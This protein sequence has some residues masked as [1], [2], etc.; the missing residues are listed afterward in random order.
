VNWLLVIGYL[1]LARDR[2]LPACKQGANNKQPRANQSQRTTDKKIW[3]ARYM[4]N[5]RPL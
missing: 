3:T 2:N 5:R 1:I 4:S